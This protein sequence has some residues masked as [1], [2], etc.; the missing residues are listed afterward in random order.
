MESEIS[1]L[2]YKISLKSIPPHFLEDIRRELTVKPIE[3]PNFPSATG[4]FPVFR[5]SKSSVYIPRHYGTEKFKIPLKNTL[6]VVNIDVGP[7]EG[8]LRPIQQETIDFTMIALEKYQGGII[9]LST[10]LGKTVIALKLINIIG[11]KTLIVV[12]A[13]FL[14]EQWIERIKQYLPA[15]KV[16]VIRQER[17][18][19]EGNDIVVG[20]LQTIISRDYPKGTFNSFSLL[21]EDECFPYNQLIIT[22]HGPMKIGM[23]YNIFKNKEILPL[24]LS[25]NELTKQTEYKK[26]TY[27]WEKENENLLKISYS[28]NDNIKCTENHKILTPNGYIE[29][30]KLKIGDL[31]QCNYGTSKITNIE[32]IKNNSNK[33]HV[34]DISIEDNHNF[35]CCNTSGLGPIVHNC[36]HVAAKSFS[37]LFYKVQ[38]KY[39]IGLSATP[40][41]KDGLSKVLYWFFGPQIVNI[42][43]ETDNPSVKFILT[44]TTGMEEKFNKLGKIN[45]PMMITDL[46][47]N[48]DRNMLIVSLI[49]LYVSQGRKILVLSDRRAHCEYLLKNL[50]GISAG[51][52]LG[53]MKTADRVI[54]TE[55]SVII[56]TYQA[57]GEGFDV[58]ELDTLILSTP[59]SDVEQAIGRILRQKNKN[60]PLI[61]DIVDSF[62]I[63]KGQVYK[64]KRFYKNNN[65]TLFN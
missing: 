42:K 29:A 64:R 38:T 46:T 4:S 30:N 62:S 33:N 8:T 53:G 26:L 12:H 7:F 24:I 14:L 3:N 60:E 58:P 10:G 43:R 16:G 45:N 54:T 35:I 57:S 25:F 61:I 20:M 63:F 18:E 44:D 51:V 17:C 40:E 23:L 19:I 52:Y 59:K 39:M 41:R 37:G 9:S 22:E 36:H 21:I 5:V 27:A 49:K 2:G 11:F 32:N 31:I 55:C 65:V 28:D 6:N 1:Q 56:G 34:Y 47:L 13:E 15:A 48:K 50:N